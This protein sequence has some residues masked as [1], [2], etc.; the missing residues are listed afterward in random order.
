[1]QDFG[2]RVF[3]LG[4]GVRWPLRFFEVASLLQSW[5]PFAMDLHSV[6]DSWLLLGLSGE[7]WLVGV[8][9]S[10]PKTPT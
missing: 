6:S 10:D 8:T 2:F 3:G 5:V 1:M 7:G 4:F 9:A